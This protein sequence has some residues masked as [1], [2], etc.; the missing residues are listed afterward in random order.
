MKLKRQILVTKL[1]ECST[2]KGGEG[3]GE[4][5]R[6]WEGRKKEER[7]GFTRSQAYIRCPT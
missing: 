6:D 3:L 4:E 5:R 7:D 1:M 2:G